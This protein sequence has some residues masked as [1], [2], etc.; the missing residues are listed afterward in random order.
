MQR[1]NIVV[2][3]A[4]FLREAACGIALFSS[5]YPTVKRAVSLSAILT[6]LTA[7]SSQMETV[8]GHG[9]IRKLLLI[10]VL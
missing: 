2:A 5:Q 10:S 1:S 7:E 3:T 8:A 6:V 9:V 4:Q